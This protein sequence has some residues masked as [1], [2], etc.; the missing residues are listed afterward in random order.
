MELKER[1]RTQWTEAAQDWIE[2]LTMSIRTGMLDSWMLG[3]LG[4]V[5]GQVRSSTSAAERAGSSR[6]LSELDATVTGID[7]DRGA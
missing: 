3:A 6:L 4:E 2:T 7:L 5:S 1:L